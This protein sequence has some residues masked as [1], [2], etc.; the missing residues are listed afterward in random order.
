LKKEFQLEDKQFV[1]ILCKEMFNLN[2]PDEQFF[3]K[4][5][6]LFKKFACSNDSQLEL[7][8]SLESYCLE[9]QKKQ[10]LPKLA[11]VL[12]K[13]FDDE[14]LEEDNIKKW[15]FGAN[16]DVKAKVAPLLKWFEEAEEEE[17]EE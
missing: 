5:S 3:S 8:K 17:E 12:H 16:A 4:Y 9:D 14:I 2:I 13:C 6:S 15:A 11:K 1:S 10:L 7:L